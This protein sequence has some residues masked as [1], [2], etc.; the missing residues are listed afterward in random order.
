MPTYRFYATVQ[1]PQDRTSGEAMGEVTERTTAAADAAV[2]KWAADEHGADAQ[3]VR[4]IEKT[5]R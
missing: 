2:R 4:L 5:G 1:I 3:N